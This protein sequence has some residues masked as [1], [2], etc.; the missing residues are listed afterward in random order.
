MITVVGERC[1]M[2]C[3]VISK[4]VNIPNVLIAVYQKHM[5]NY[6]YQKLLSHPF[7]VIIPKS[8]MS[9]PVYQNFMIRYR[10]KNV[11]NVGRTIDRE[12]MV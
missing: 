9:L 6:T 4:C 11:I 10:A 5:C 12:Y 8:V 7:G 1:S 2:S 3:V